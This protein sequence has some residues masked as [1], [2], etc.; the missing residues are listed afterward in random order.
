MDILVPLLAIFSV[1][2]VP[3][4]GLVFILTT[5]FAFKPLVESLS[6]ALRESGHGTSDRTARQIRELRE[7]VEDLTAEVARLQELRDFDRELLA[8]RSGEDRAIR[9]TA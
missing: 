2:F 1:I 6:K 9:P 7:H 3:V 4:T 5:R 8:E